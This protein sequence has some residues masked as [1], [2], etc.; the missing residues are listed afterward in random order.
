MRTIGVRALRENPGILNQCAAR[1][2]FVL[3]TS[4]NAPISLAVPFNDELI[5]AG[6]HISVAVKLYEDGLLSLTKAA[7]I[8]GMSTES[9]LDKLAHLKI[10]V[11]D[12]SSEELDNDLKALA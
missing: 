2:E 9:F 8:A 11:V 6:A 7:A 3:V 4:R 1:G 10:V 5:Q 12:Q